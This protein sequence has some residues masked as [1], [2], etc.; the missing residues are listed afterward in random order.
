MEALCVGSTRYQICICMSAGPEEAPHSLHLVLH[1]HGCGGG[2]RLHC[3]QVR[4]LCAS[5]TCLPFSCTFTQRDC[6]TRL[7]DH[8]PRPSLQLWRPSLTIYPSV[9]YP[10]VLRSFQT[11]HTCFRMLRA[12]RFQY[13]P[14]GLSLVGLTSP[15][16]L[17][18]TASRSWEHLSVS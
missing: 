7:L 11:L 3:W 16:P 4:S 18:T 6:S 12:L 17:A 10:A 5:L 1:L 9:L 15:T 14:H 13:L 8:H 2:W